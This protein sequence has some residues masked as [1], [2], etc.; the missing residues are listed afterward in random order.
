MDKGIEKAWSDFN[1]KYP[2]LAGSMPIPDLYDALKK[3]G[4]V[5]NLKDLQDRL[6]KLKDQGKAILEIVSSPTLEPRSDY[7]IRTDRGLLFYVNF[8]KEL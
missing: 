7:A 6:M 4:K 5:K 2:Y 8:P 1:K 3:E